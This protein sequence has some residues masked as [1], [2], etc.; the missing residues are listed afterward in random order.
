MVFI[1]MSQADIVKG[2]DSPLLSMS[3]EKRVVLAGFFRDRSSPVLNQQA[4][5]LL[6]SMRGHFNR[7][8][9]A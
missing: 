6:H 5:L 2:A 9:S 1:H 3:V 7:I 4:D 8:L